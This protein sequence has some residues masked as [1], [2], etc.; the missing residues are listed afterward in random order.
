VFHLF[1]ARVDTEAPSVFATLDVHGG[2]AIN[3]LVTRA[4][5]FF[6]SKHFAE[7]LNNGQNLAHCCHGVISHAVD[8][9]E[10][11][12]NHGEQSETIAY[13][14]QLSHMPLGDE[15]AENAN[16]SHVLENGK[17]ETAHDVKPEDVLDLLFTYVDHF[18]AVV[19][20]PGVG[21]DSADTRDHIVD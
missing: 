3:R 19:S 6:H 5:E 15:D 11:V 2:F 13:I 1:L 9:E 17:A 18:L 14:K 16:Q 12:V 4:F 7:A 20:L 21:F 10:K 8:V